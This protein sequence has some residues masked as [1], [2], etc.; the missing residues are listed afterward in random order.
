[1]NEINKTTMTH[2]DAVPLVQASFVAIH[3]E[4]FGAIRT[5]YVVIDEYFGNQNNSLERSLESS[6][7][8]YSAAEL[9]AQNID[10]NWNHDHPQD[11]DVQYSKVDQ[12]K[13]YGAWAAGIVLGF[14]L[15]GGPS[16]SI[17]FGIGAAYF[18]QQEEGVVGDV[19][20]A[21]G[22]VALL[23][24]EKFVEVNEKH[25]II[26]TVATVTIA[27]SRNCLVSVRSLF[28]AVD[29]K[30]RRPTRQMNT[31]DTETT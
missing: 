23:S 24:H 26:D 5:E 15:G 1:M 6:N 27:F 29:K 3:A 9:T 30:N 4:P 17:A 7:S 22:D 31:E 21:I 8:D 10:S 13:T 14:V 12:S 28:S 25:N 18:S 11:F 2:D 20:R 19:A 16:L